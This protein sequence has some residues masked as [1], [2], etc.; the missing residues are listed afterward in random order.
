MGYFRW[1]IALLTLGVV[2]G[3]GSAIAHFAHWH[4]HGYGHGPC[5][6][7]WSSGRWSDA[8]PER[9]QQNSPKSVQ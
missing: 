3:Y 2:L 5:H 9:G 6:D 4:G 1:R 8:P 7:H